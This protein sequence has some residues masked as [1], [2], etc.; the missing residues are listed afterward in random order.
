MVLMKVEVV[1]GEEEG[2]GG[3]SEDAYVVVDGDG[4]SLVVR[5]DSDGVH[6]GGGSCQEIKKEGKEEVV[7][8]MVVMWW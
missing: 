7:R 1:V 8:V 3:A 5:G 2:G 4:G 6:K